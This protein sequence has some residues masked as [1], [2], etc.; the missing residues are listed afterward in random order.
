M[1]ISLSILAVILYSFILGTAGINPVK[2]GPL[3]IIACGP[4]PRF[5]NATDILDTVDTVITLV[6]P[7]LAIFIMNIRIAYKVVSFYRQRKCVARRQFS[8]SSTYS[9]HL[10]GEVSQRSNVIYTK[11]QASY[12]NHALYTIACCASLFCKS[13]SCFCFLPCTV[14]AFF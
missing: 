6:I 2:I 8:E 14:L 4:L 5:R 1:V 12:V 9:R 10:Q 7:F 13:S 3:T 11:T